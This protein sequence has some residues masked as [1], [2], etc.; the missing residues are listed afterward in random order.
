VDS[1]KA[2]FAIPGAGGLAVAA[3]FV[4]KALSHSAAV[5]H[6]LNPLRY[7]VAHITP[8]VEEF[9]QKGDANEVFINALCT[10]VT[11][12]LNQRPSGESVGSFVTSQ[13]SEQT[14]GY[15]VL[16][17]QEKLDQFEAALQLSQWDG[18]VASKYIQVCGRTGFP[19]R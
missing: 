13:I 8:H 12:E 6:D 9:V 2:G 18:G 4:A 10:V 3:L 7:S 15:S 17:P 11:D 5:I 19:R 14:V 16:L 1:R